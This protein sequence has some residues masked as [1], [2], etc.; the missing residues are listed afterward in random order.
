MS[1][2]EV[3]YK[4]AIK[5][6]IT[7]NAFEALRDFQSRGLIKSTKNQAALDKLIEYGSYLSQAKTQPLSEYLPKATR[8]RGEFNT[9]VEVG[10]IEESIEK[11]KELQASLAMQELEDLEP[12]EFN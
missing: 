8:L 12:G 11:G 1:S 7:S 9:E 6:L 5:T 2:K 4:D 3:F 10:L